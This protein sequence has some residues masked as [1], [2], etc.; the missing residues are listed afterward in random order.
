MR[1]LLFIAN[2]HCTGM[3]RSCHHH[4]T[5]KSDAAII[6]VIHKSMK[7]CQIFRDGY[8][9]FIL[10]SWLQGYRKL[11]ANALTLYFRLTTLTLRS[12]WLLKG[13]KRLL[14]LALFL[15]LNNCN[16]YALMCINRVQ[17]S[18]DMGGKCWEQVRA[19]MKSCSSAT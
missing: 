4:E 17:Y 6:G 5:H 7:G 15:T 13:C 11:C 16:E 8:R 19:L 3:V 12:D 2:T 9:P 1:C 18:A 10:N 14:F